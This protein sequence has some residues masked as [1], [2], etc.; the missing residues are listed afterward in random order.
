MFAWRSQAGAPKEGQRE[1]SPLPAA[2]PRQGREEARFL[3]A[4]CRLLALRSD[5]WFS[6]TRQ[7]G[8]RWEPCLQKGAIHT[9]SAG[10]DLAQLLEELFGVRTGPPGCLGLVWGEQCLGLHRRN[11]GC[12]STPALLLCR[13]P[14]AGVVQGLEV[15]W[16]WVLQLL[17][18]AA[19]GFLSLL[20]FCLAVDGRAAQSHQYLAGTSRWGLRASLHSR[21]GVDPCH[22]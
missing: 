4:P 11:L 9:S 2:E 5:I 19:G 7:G 18:S 17:G 6:A 14:A 3:M 8:G 16:C 20:K 15:G 12:S 1:A 10:R 21:R 13:R 22:S